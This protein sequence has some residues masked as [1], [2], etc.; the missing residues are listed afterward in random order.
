M[1]KQLMKII[2]MLTLLPII[3]KKENELLHEIQK[4]QAAKQKK[5]DEKLLHLQ[6]KKMNPKNQ[7][8]RQQQQ[9]S[10]NFSRLAFLNENVSS[11]LV[12]SSPKTITW[13]I[14]KSLVVSSAVQ[15]KAF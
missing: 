1:S 12:S 15:S 5:R 6:I 10:S 2:K 9:L 4:D 14:K 13:P 11:R 3:I 8:E 7:E